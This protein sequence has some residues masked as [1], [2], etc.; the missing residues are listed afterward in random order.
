MAT[1]GT[2]PAPIARRAVLAG[3]A[4]LSTTALTTLGAAGDAR[5]HATSTEAQVSPRSAGSLTYKGVNFDTD[6]DVWRTEYVRREIAAIKEQLHCDAVLLLGHDLDRLTEA[7]SI[8]AAHGLFVWFEPRQFDQDAERTLAFLGSVARAA[9]RLR[10]RHPGVGVALGTELT[11]FMSGLVPGKD[12][13][14]RG[15]ALARPESAGFQERLNAFLDR[16]LQTVRPLFHGRVTYS[17]GEWEEVDWRAFDVLGVNLYRNAENRATYTRQLRA[18]HRHGKPVVITE[19]GCCTF[20]G[21]GDQGGM[22]FNAVDWEREPPVV[23]DGYVRDEREQADEI[24][25]LLDLYAAERVHGAFVYNFIAPD[26][27]HSPRR[28]HDLDIASFALA[29]TF[30]TGNRRG[31]AETG[32]WEPKRSFAA[33]ARRFR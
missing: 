19:F 32:Q 11:I 24:G 3:A 5:A 1:D 2:A 33:V 25:E 12:Y 22:G 14:E 23:K 21:A 27:P 4:A 28:R 20:T 6:R 7:A 10:A 17:S 26:S 31:Y 16:A 30:P 9:E 8:A 29:K 18:L 15:Q 13:I